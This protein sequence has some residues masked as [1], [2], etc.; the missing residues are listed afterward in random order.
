MGF[1]EK[2]CLPRF[3]DW[4]CG[5]DVIKAQREKVVPLAEGR[6]LEVGIGTGLNL[7]FYHPEKVE[8]IWGLE[9]SEGMR[10]RAQANLARTSLEVRWLD[11]PGEEIP[12]EKNSVDT[13]LLTYTLCTIPD[14]STALQQMRRV[15]K[16]GG[17]LIFCEHGL[18]PDEKV[19]RWQARVNP[20]WKKVAGGCNLNRPIPDY[21]EQAGFHITN[22]QT[23]Y[24]PGAPKLASFNYW[25]TAEV[26]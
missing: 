10:R 2:Y 24:L 20:V 22:L 26:R 9:P 5:M 19:Q 13:I 11:L 18:A 15:L 7:P 23:Q 1:Y 17:K 3:L 14:W 8:M 21:L 16:S 4:A 25:G 6:V 12:L